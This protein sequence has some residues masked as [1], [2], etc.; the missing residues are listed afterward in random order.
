MATTRLILPDA[1]NLENPFPIEI[2][3]R[4]DNVNF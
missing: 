1:K 3:S 2:N 4:I